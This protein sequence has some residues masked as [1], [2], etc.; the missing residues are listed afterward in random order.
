MRVR[1]PDEELTSVGA[2]SSA[3]AIFYE[4]QSQ[5]QDLNDWVQGGYY[6]AHP[7]MGQIC[8]VTNVIPQPMLV[9]GILAATF[10]YDANEPASFGAAPEHGDEY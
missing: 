7:S 2:S 4:R 5:A 1:N 8:G 9:L 3:F 10:S 6:V